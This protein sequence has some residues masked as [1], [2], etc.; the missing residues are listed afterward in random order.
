MTSQSDLAN[1]T[2]VAALENIVSARRRVSHCSAPATC[3]Y[4]QYHSDDES[5]SQLAARLQDIAERA[6]IE[7]GEA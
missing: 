5:Y 4:S 2:L 1:R 3:L 7:T 6:L